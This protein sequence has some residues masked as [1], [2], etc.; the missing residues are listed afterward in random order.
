MALAIVARADVPEP[1]EAPEPTLLRRHCSYCARS[2][3]GQGRPLDAPQNSGNQPLVP[4][5]ILSH[6]VPEQCCFYSGSS[7]AYNNIVSPI[8]LVGRGYAVASI[9]CI[10]EITCSLSLNRMACMPMALAASTFAGKSSTKLASAGCTPS[11]LA[12]S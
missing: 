12:A 9:C 7:P 3:A 4:V 5:R 2:H 10:C 8:S 11:R 1:H 6:T